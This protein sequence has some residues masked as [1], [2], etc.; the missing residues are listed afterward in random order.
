MWGAHTL[1]VNEP[2]IIWPLDTV[3]PLNWLLNIKKKKK[4]GQGCDTEDQTERGLFEVKQIVAG[5][6]LALM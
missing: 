2:M 1:I 3:Y 6:M 5:S 4:L